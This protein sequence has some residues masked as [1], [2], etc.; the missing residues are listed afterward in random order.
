MNVTHVRNVSLDI[1]VFTCG[2]LV[3]AFE[4]IGSRVL[5]PYI[6]AS[7]Y[8]WT[9]LIG[10][11]L[12]SL[13]LGYWLGGRLADRRPD[14]R[15]LASVIFFAGGLISVMVLVKDVVLSFAASAPVAIELRS[16]AV[17]LLLFAPASVCLGIVTPYAIR[18]R[19][20]N[21]ADSGKTVGRLYALSTVGSIVGTFLAGFVL[22]PFVGTNRTLY[23]IAACLIGTSLLLSPF[24]ISKARIGVFVLFAMSIAASEMNARLLFAANGLTDID[25]RYARVRVFRT[26]EP[27]SGQALQAMATDPYFI[28]SA[29]LMDSDDLAFDYS[30]YYHLARHF[31][32]GFR[33]VLVIGG[34][35]Y[36]V[37]KELLRKYDDI[38]LDVVEIDPGMTDIAKRYFRLRDDPRLNIVHED[39]RTYIGRSEIAK[40]DVVMMDASGSL[41]SVPYQ[42]TTIEAVQQMRRAL[43]D[44]GVMIFNLGSAIRGPASRFLNAELSTYRS[45]FDSVL[46]FK[47]NADYPDERLQN[48]II[49]AANRTLPPDMHSDDTE[50]AEMLKHAYRDDIPLITRPLTD[51]LAPVEYYNAI[52]LDNYIA[53]G[54]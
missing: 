23:L 12:A 15:V 24:A 4:I 8:V 16:V 41:F 48:V 1:A 3:M 20:T 9:S 6:G 50:I 32:P 45:V 35:G 34:A 10:V 33:K 49:V 21:V 51:D 7:I 37:P 19:M 13:S 2:A 22:L 36:S 18:L 38:R 42:L 53:E 17:A 40:Y 26:T 44:D 43:K 52:A 29:M 46:V 25:T 27:R 5:T 30:R 28:Q 39:G 14:V 47:V 54:H 31:R 11:I